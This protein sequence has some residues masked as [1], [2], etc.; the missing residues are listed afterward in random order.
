MITR[1]GGPDTDSRWT[2]S[3][4]TQKALRQLRQTEALRDQLEGR[5]SRLELGAEA[6]GEEDSTGTGQPG[7]YTSLGPGPHALEL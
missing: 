7:F 3:E 4:A 2:Q 5:G 1:P 6:V